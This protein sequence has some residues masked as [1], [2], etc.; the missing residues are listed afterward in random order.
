MPTRVRHDDP[1]VTTVD[2][3]IIHWGATAR[4]AIELPAV[5]G[6]TPGTVIRIVLGGTTSFT[7]P[8][9]RDARLLITGA[10]DTPGQARGEGDGPNRV[11]RWVDDR[12]LSRGRTVHIDVVAP[13]Y[14][15]GV[16]APGETAVYEGSRP[17]TALSEI[18]RDL[19]DG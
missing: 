18:A 6:V 9:R 5:D 2:G 13:T 15:I 17:G 8:R 10:Y 7:R 19:E 14:R 11:A 1:S 12:G 3:T 16:R 4:P